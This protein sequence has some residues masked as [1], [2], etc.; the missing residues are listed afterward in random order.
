MSA[1]DWRDTPWQN[2]NTETRCVFATSA[3]RPGDIQFGSNTSYFGRNLTEAVRNGSVPESRVD[4]MATRILGGYFLLGQDD[5]T[6][7]NVSFDS[8]D[9]YGATVNDFVDV[10]DDHDYIVRRVAE[11]STVLLKNENATLPLLS[12]RRMAVIGSAAGPALRGPNGI[13]GKRLHT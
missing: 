9:R 13:A 6:Y 5:P 2:A 8:F 3:T 12:P 4:D 1:Y 7:P 10:R 11:G